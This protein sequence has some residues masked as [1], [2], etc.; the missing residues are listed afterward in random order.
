MKKMMAGFVCVLIMVLMSSV[1][2]AGLNEEYLL[3][4]AVTSTGAE[5]A[6]VVKQAYKSWGCD[7]KITGG[8]TAVVVR[9]EGNQGTN[10]FDPTG[11]AEFTMD[12]G[13][14]AAGIGTFVIVEHTVKNIRG[15]LITLT[16]G[17]APTVTLS[18]IGRD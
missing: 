7:V 9:V 5:T 12:A 3:L 18:C 15:N 2:H 1:A 8:P 14:L 11:M 6:K 10:I 4:D 13:Q 17:T 16:G